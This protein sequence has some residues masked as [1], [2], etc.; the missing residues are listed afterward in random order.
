MQRLG[1]FP[2]R[3]KEQIKHIREDAETNK[4]ED[5]FIHAWALGFSIAHINRNYVDI[6]M[7]SILISASLSSPFPWSITIILYAI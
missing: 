4:S 7:S 6:K 1:L 3:K 2:F 5:E